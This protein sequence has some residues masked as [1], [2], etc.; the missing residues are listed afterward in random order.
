MSLVNVLNIVLFSAQE[1]TWSR[2]R[3]WWTLTCR[4]TSL[5]NPTTTRTFIVSAGPVGLASTALPSTWSMDHAHVQC[6]N[7]LNLTLVCQLSGSQSSKTHFHFSYDHMLWTKQRHVTAE[8]SNWSFL[9]TVYILCTVSQKSIPDIFVSI[10]KTNCQILII[11]G[12]NVPH[13][14]CHQ[15]TIHFLTSPNICFCTT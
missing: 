2:L 8:I 11:F 10:L 14:T 9:C 5:I 12:K 13:T 15:M 1:L 6:C 7:R 4:W 3:W